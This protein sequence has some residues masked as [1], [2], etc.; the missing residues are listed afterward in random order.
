MSRGFDAE[1]PE[2]LSFCS[3][4]CS[5]SSRIDVGTTYEHYYTMNVVMGHA[6]RFLLPSS[7]LVTAKGKTA[8]TVSTTAALRC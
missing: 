6:V 2:L 5:C 8:V 7:T 1:V 4:C 3:C